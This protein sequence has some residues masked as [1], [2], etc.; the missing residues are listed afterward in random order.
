MR[1][2]FF[3]AKTKLVNFLLDNGIMEGGCGYTKFI[4]LGMGRTGSNFLAT[5]LQSQKNVI[6]FG[7]IFNNSHQDRVSW[8]YPGYRSTRAALELRDRDPQAFINTLVFR[9]MRRNIAAVGFKLF[10]Y[11]ARETQWACIWPYLRDMQGLKIIHLK[12]R[13]LL[14]TYLS[15]SRALNDR[16]WMARSEAR[17]A[18]KEALELDYN[19]VLKGFRNIRQWED[20]NTRYFSGKPMLDVYYEDLTGDYPREMSRVQEF[21]GLPLVPARPLTRKQSVQGLA[22]SISN[23]EELKNRFGDSEWR[24]FFEE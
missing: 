20:E 21:L 18:R 22:E 19:E 4:I 5:S 16:Q 23:Y 17:V 7:E 2:Q 15:M 11:H 1:K 13:N 14:K 3:I 12:R 9:R 24:V 8:M 6:A 10:Y